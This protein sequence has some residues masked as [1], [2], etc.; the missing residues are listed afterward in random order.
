MRAFQSTQTRI[1]LLLSFLSTAMLLALYGWEN[2]ERQQNA[3][4]DRALRD[5]EQQ[6]ATQVVRVQTTSGRDF[7]QVVSKLALI[8][9]HFLQHGSPDFEERLTRFAHMSGIDG[10]ILLDAHAKIDLRLDTFGGLDSV[11]DRMDLERIPDLI[12]KVPFDP[13]FFVRTP[14][15]VVN[16]AVEA[17]R[18]PPNEASPGRLLGYVISVNAWDGSVYQEMSDACASRV[19]LASNT[20]KD[21]TAP[22]ADVGL[23]GLNGYPV[24]TIRFTNEKTD[25]RK[26]TVYSPNTYLFGI[27]G[28]LVVVA[29]MAYCLRRWVTRPVQ[30]LLNAL[31]TEDPRELTP[32]KKS[33]SEFGALAHSLQRLFDTLEFQRQA[34]ENAR[35]AN[36]A[37]SEFLAN[38]SHEIRT[39]M[40][41]VIGMAGLLLDQPLD[42]TARD[43]A[44]T[45]AQSADS[46]LTVINDVLDFSKIESGRVDI[47]CVEFSVGTLVEEVAE[48]LAFRAV[49][50]GI[51]LACEISPNIPD[52]VLGDPI[53]IRQ[54]LMNLLGNA[55]KFTDRGEI[56]MRASV[57]TDVPHQTRLR[58]SVM[59]TGIGIP[60]ERQTAIFESFTQ[61]DGG[62]TRK[63]GGTG[64]GLTI[65]KRLTELM[66]GQISVESV[67]GLGSTFTVELELPKSHHLAP[68]MS[69]GSSR[70]RGAQ[71][72][73]V[74]D[75]AVSRRILSDVLTTWGAKVL[76]CRSGIEALAELERL[77]SGDV[78]VAIVDLQM[79]GLD[80]EQFATRLRLTPHARM[81]MILAS[82]VGVGTHEHWRHRGF[83]ASVDKPIRRAALMGALEEA[84]GRQA[85]APAE[86]KPAEAPAGLRILVAEDNPTNQKVAQRI[87]EKAGHEVVIAPDGVAALERLERQ[88]FSLI[89]MDCQMPNMDGYAATEEIRRR[90]ALSEAPRI[91]ILAM[92]A[93]ATV[94]DRERCLACGM[95]D[96]ITKPVRPKDL[97][98]L[99]VHWT[100]G[101]SAD[102][103]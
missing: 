55:I 66:G 49:E 7:V 37:K 5:R 35:A 100:S 17:V 27:L 74:D 97:L 63:Y 15:G 71:V 64:L 34:E 60:P 95:N 83:A 70:V 67:V 19:V 46:L 21:D 98:D 41:G 89:L 28:V 82:S 94:A 85:I 59:D 79:P 9:M 53:R 93:N 13:V 10:V 11:V 30:L 24:A 22:F 51:E 6:L 72:L 86:P 101:E 87:L 32:V 84:L 76:A 36:Q 102:V 42:P 65:T 69:V 25:M 99:V 75:N 58:L 31:Y 90:E 14:D 1:V 68:S 33:N 96:F 57:V 40:N 18:I 16:C 73:V 39:P 23:Y 52:G 80:G 62:T 54:I 92:T 20:N 81:P 56:V 44:K 3:L 38:V 12:A 4:V 91:P 43:Y 88:P 8:R 103:A 47:D 77:P 26:L 61:A 48:V 45:I 2:A 50:K 78:T 29:V